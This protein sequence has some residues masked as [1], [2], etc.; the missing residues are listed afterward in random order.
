MYKPPINSNRVKYMRSKFENNEVTNAGN[1]DVRLNNA[2]IQSRQKTINCQLDKKCNALAKRECS[3]FDLKTKQPLLSRQLS[4]PLNKCNIKRT[5]AFRLEKNPSTHKSHK[6]N[7]L[8]NKIKI[9]DQRLKPDCDNN[10]ENVHTTSKNNLTKKNC[11]RDV[12]SVDSSFDN[13]FSK[14]TAEEKL[15]DIIKLS[16]D[17]EDI[18][19]A[20]LKFLYAEPIPKAYRH[21]NTTTPSENN[22]DNSTHDES[23]LND[24]DDIHQ[25][26]T[27]KLTDAPSNDSQRQRPKLLRTKAI[28]L[29]DSEIEFKTV[30]LTDTLKNALK[31]P[32]PSGPAPKKPPRTFVHSPK[33]N[34]SPENEDVTLDK[35]ICHLKLNK[36]FTNELNTSLQKCLLETAKTKPKSKNDP[37]YMLNKLEH[38]LRNNK[39][40][41]KKQK[42]LEN[43]SGEESD[44]DQQL[45]SNTNTNSSNSSH[46]NMFNLNCLSALTCSNTTYERIKEPNSSFF[47]KSGEE[48]VYAIPFQ[49]PVDVSD[50]VPDPGNAQDAEHSGSL[51]RNSLYYM[52]SIY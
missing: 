43:T 25:S 12:K 37:M 27:L 36:S 18:S 4:D 47:V 49:G 15:D 44:C 9:F 48:P 45:L 33:T 30:D 42:K 7:F 8:E 29:S 51:K 24:T 1:G 11:L 50:S 31:R 19:Y 35:T 6:S 13:K 38:A 32:L 21:K 3:S 26:S 20:N 5:P 14:K 40:R 2:V 22:V 17:N 10:D 46:G 52:V 34:Q 41:L 28:D 39:I 23:L 16:D